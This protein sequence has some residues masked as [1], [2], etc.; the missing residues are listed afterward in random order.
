MKV[1]DIINISE[2]KYDLVNMSV[3]VLLHDNGFMRYSKLTP[4]NYDYW[5]CETKNPLDA[6]KNVYTYQW[7]DMQK[8]M[9]FNILMKFSKLHNPNDSLYKLLNNV[10]N[11][12][13]AFDD[14]YDMKTGMYACEDIYDKCYGKRKAY[15]VQ[16][17]LF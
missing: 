9:K 3:G 10:I 4:E 5:W 7:E 17:K 6:K 12:I 11:I 14:G 15:P 1:Q 8:T 2:C 16:L 13:S